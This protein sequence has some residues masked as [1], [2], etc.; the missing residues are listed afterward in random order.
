MEYTLDKFNVTVSE[1]RKMASEAQ[2]Y[3]IGGFD[4]EEGIEDA[5]ARKKVLQQA[6]TKI[7]KIGKAMRDDA[8]A[9]A[10]LV[11]NKEKELLDIIVPVEDEIK[12]RLEEVDRLK[13]LE[14]R[15]LLLPNR[16]DDMK[17]LGVDISD[18]ELLSMNATQYDMFKSDKKQEKIDR[19][20]QEM[21]AEKAKIQAEREKLDR[22]KE[23]EEAKKRAAEQAIVN[24]KRQDE[25]D[26]ENRRQADE[27]AKKN[28]AYKDWYKSLGEGEFKVIRTG[29]TF[30]A[31][32]KVSEITID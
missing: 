21:Q 20:Y 23:L 3:N 9:F 32:R 6:R 26:A 7:K 10:K 13:E 12:A 19:E 1:L 25:I 2:N 4:D 8:N 22:E 27:R 29:N 5:K 11:I 17:D 15:K 14:E 24:K 18:E 16:R 30:T 31:Y 28:K